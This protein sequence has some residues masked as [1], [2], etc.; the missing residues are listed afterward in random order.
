MWFFVI[1]MKQ[2][3]DIIINK[4]RNSSNTRKK[5]AIAFFLIWRRGIERGRGWISYW[6]NNVRLLICIIYLNYYQMKWEGK[7]KNN[8]RW[9]EGLNSQGA[10]RKK[11]RKGGE[12][13]FLIYFHSLMMMGYVT[14]NKKMYRAYYSN[15]LEYLLT[16]E[17]SIV[18][19]IA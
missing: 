8:K 17:Y 2:W 12:V 14:F 16:M 5:L 11:E 13:F 6:W 10:K 7:R 3:I 4:F 1:S 9:E 15:L 18:H 19:H